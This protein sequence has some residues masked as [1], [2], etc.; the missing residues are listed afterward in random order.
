MV[1]P[2]SANSD[3]DHWR[4]EKG[5]WLG[6]LRPRGCAAAVYECWPKRL[7]WPGQIIKAHLPSVPLPCHHV[8]TQRRTSLLQGNLN[9]HGEIVLN[10]RSKLIHANKES[11]SR[12]IMHRVHSS[13]RCTNRLLL[14][15]FNCIQWLSC[16]EQTLMYNVLCFCLPC[17]KLK[18]IQRGRGTLSC[19]LEGEL[20]HDH[21]DSC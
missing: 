16:G 14:R 11:Y 9:W 13:V 12:I 15:A 4:R 6:F 8:K 17:V 7:D 21:H 18:A 5:Q 2:F 1:P 10:T 3:T 20:S 19:F